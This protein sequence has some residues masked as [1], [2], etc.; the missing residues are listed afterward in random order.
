MSHR[1]PDLGPSSRL[2]FRPAA[3]RMIGADLLVNVGGATG[4]VQRLDGAG[5]EI[6]KA[7]AGGQTIAEAAT[8]LADRAGTSPSQAVRIVHDFATE[9]V[10]AGLAEPTL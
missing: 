7:F 1:Q 6:W 5:P 9:L 8:T 10:R 3:T 4:L 2:E